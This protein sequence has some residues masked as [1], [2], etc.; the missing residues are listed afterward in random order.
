MTDYGVPDDPQGALPWAWAQERL[1]RSRNLW[2]ATSSTS[3][4]P[5]A[6]PVW[7][8]WRTDP[9][10]FQ[11][12]CAPSSRKARNIA[13]NP[14]VCVMADDTV[15][16]VSVDGVATALVDDAERHDMARHY[17]EKYWEPH[18]YAEMTDFLLSHAIF[19]VRPVRAYGVIERDEEFSAKATRWRW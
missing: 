3:G 16:V 14:Q 11:F 9:D 15:E 13:A 19:E 10:R 17:V 18:Q 7:G 2:V 8:V 5:A 1:V 6:T 12:S 4:R